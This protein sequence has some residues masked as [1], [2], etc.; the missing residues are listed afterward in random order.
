[1]GWGWGCAAKADRAGDQANR[2]A[3]PL[4]EHRRKNRPTS[5]PR[6]CRG[7][8]QDL[9]KERLFFPTSKNNGK[10]R[11]KKVI[12]LIFYEKYTGNAILKGK[13]LEEFKLH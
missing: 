11:Y 2:Q 1:M 3:E 5:G 9:R 10:T 8:K 4:L 12:S 6:H 7:S 13:I